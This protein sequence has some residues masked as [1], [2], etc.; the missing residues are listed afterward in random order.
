MPN[1]HLAY[2]TNGGN[3]VPSSDA[4]L[5]QRA[6]KQ[7]WPIP[8]EAKA[9]W[10]ARMDQMITHGDDRSAN[11]AL[12]SAIQMEGQNQQDQMA[13]EYIGPGGGS[14]QVRPL[15]E[16]LEA[17]R[18]SL[19]VLPQEYTEEIIDAEIVPAPHGFGEGVFDDSP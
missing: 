8:A 15:H 18:A 19:P 5:L 13:A 9:R 16:E 3:G 6:I 17:M 4:R 12:R 7:R 14:V 11:A 10:V 1:E 2:S